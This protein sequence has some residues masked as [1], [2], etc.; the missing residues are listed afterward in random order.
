[1]VFPSCGYRYLFF[2]RPELLHPLYLSERF[3]DFSPRVFK[4]F[5]VSR[6]LRKCGVAFYPWAA[7]TGA[8]IKNALLSHF[9]PASSLADPFLARRTGSPLEEFALVSPAVHRGVS[10]LE[11]AQG[12]LK[13]ASLFES[14]R[15]PLT[16]PYGRRVAEFRKP[17][18]GFCRCSVKKDVDGIPLN[19]APHVDC[20]NGQPSHVQNRPERDDGWV[21]GAGCKVLARFTRRRF[22]APHASIAVWSVYRHAPHA[23]IGRRLLFI[24][25]F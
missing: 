9:R 16:Q 11:G 25:G 4:P 14:S 15:N 8:V 1:M 20:P 3:T 21:Y 6:A 18:G 24:R 23:Q 19:G 7:I 2:V 12:V 5:L 17:V 22:V 13:A 10:F